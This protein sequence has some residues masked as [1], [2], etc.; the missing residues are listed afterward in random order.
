[1]RAGDAVRTTRKPGH[2]LVELAGEGT[3]NALTPELVAALHGVLDRAEADPDCRLVVF[4][5]TGEAFCAGSHL[6]RLD[7]ERFRGLS[8]GFWELLRRISGSRLPAVALVEGWAAGGGVGLAAACDVVIAAP[9]ATFRL[10]E[11]CFGMLPTIV[12]PWVAR[13]VGE[14]RALRLA[15]LAERL[16]AADAQRCGLVDVVDDAPREALRRVLAAVRRSDR[17]TLG[18]LK[19]V[20]RVLFPVDNRYGLLAER[21]FGARIDDPKVSAR[22]RALVEE[23]LL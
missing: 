17:D 14:H 1:M 7:A 9:P 16:T 8:T 18:D 3:R 2:L 11:V 4:A 12:M 10:T 21:V 20:H 15:L 5:A 13:R 6:T 22:I 19:D 23:G